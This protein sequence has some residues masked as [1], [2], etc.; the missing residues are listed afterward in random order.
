MVALQQSSVDH[1]GPSGTRWK[2]RQPEHVEYTARSSAGRGI[3]ETRNA[4]FK[5][6]RGIEARPETAQEPGLGRRWRQR[7]DCAIIAQRHRS[8]LTAK[9]VFYDA[10]HSCIAG[11][12]DFHS[13]VVRP[14][15]QPSH[16]PI[17]LYDRH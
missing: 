10:P 13:S 5:L 2:G 16:G 6:R 15:H 8:A 4:L 12:R 14:K 3:R 11:A 17:W 7:E 1:H 9:E